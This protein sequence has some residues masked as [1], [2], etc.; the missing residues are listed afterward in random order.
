M[1][2]SLLKATFSFAA[3]HYQCYQKLDFL[4]MYETYVFLE[5]SRENIRLQ[6]CRLTVR[7]NNVFHC[8]NF[9]AHFGG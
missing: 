4:D 1:P 2:F 7:G 6:Q 8:L 3:N 5:N 9:E